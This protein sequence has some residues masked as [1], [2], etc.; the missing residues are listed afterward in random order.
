VGA[1]TAVSGRGRI[2]DSAQRQ[3][4]PA[5]PRAEAETEADADSA[6]LTLFLP[7]QL[8]QNLSLSR[9]LIAEADFDAEYLEVVDGTKTWRIGHRD[10]D[11]HGDVGEGGWEFK[12]QN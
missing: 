10:G 8:T 9:P 4:S 11:G 7:L 1:A 6:I 2:G 12:I 3:Q 5:A